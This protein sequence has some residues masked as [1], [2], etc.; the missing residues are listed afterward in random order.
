MRDIWK[1]EPGS[2]ADQSGR[3]AAEQRCY[4]LLDSLGVEYYRV[5]HA[6]ADT[7]EECREV[8][9]T[10]D[11]LICRRAPLPPSGTRQDAE[12]DTVDRDA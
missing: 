9:K 5:D 3:I 10:L 11:A 7:M 12:P 2:P 8:E 6:H 1:L 4:Q